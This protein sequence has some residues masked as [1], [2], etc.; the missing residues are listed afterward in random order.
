MFKIRLDSV[1]IVLQPLIFML[2]NVQMQLT[3]RVDV[4][5]RRTLCWAQFSHQEVMQLSPERLKNILYG[6]TRNQKIRM[7]E[8]F[9]CVSVRFFIGASSGAGHSHQPC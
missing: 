1:H 6:T 4:G 9:L 2:I 5:F 8:C 3:F 7:S